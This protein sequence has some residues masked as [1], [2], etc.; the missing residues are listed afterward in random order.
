MFQMLAATT[1]MTA[2]NWGV[3][4]YRST[5]LLLFSLTALFSGL[6][7]YFQRPVSTRLGSVWATLMIGQVALP[8]YLHSPIGDYKRTVASVLLASCFCVLIRPFWWQWPVSVAGYFILATAYIR[9]PFPQ[10]DLWY[11]QENAIALLGKGLS[12]YSLIHYAKIPLADSWVRSLPYPPAHVIAIW[13]GHWFGD[14]R[15]SLVI[16]ILIGALALKVLVPKTGPRWA[17][18][19]G[20]LFLFYPKSLLY[21]WRAWTEPTLIG[22]FGLALYSKVKNYPRLLIFALGIAL[23]V[24]QFGFIFLLALYA[25]RTIS[26]RVCL[27]SALAGLAILLPF[28]IADPS[29]L[30][31]GTI[32][33]H[34]NTPPRPD[35]WSIPAVIHAAGGP[36][37]GGVT[38]FISLAMGLAI[39][40]RIGSKI[41][42]ASGLSS[43]SSGL[44]AAS[45]L[46]L[47]FFL[48]SPKAHE[49]YYFMPLF[50]TMAAL[51]SHPRQNWEKLGLANP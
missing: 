36:Q 47:V 41:G 25:T 21:M 13:L 37:L 8:A 12:P 23:T 43:L 14:F 20:L 35:S 1:C 5:A 32:L 4:E 19:I 46:Y 10:F 51:A 15:W 45:F 7:I 18:V 42:Q 39:V 26:L 33:T 34:L 31:A 17:T 27:A 49:N 30:I 16:G 11:L 50:L 48:M 38:P 22:A 6:A 3:Y 9:V 44:S 29:G 28:L 40:W 2:L 24:K